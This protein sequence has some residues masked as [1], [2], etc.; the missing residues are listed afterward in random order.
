MKSKKILLLFLVVVLSVTMAAVSVAC[1]NKTIELA[2]LEGLDAEIDLD[3]NTVKVT[4]DSSLSILALPKPVLTEEGEIGYE[5][6]RDSLLKNIVE[7]D[8]VE[9]EYGDNTFYLKVYFAKSPKK[10]VKYHVIVTR[11]QPQTPDN[12]GGRQYGPFDDVFDGVFDFTDSGKPYPS[13]TDIS[14]EEFCALLKPYYVSAT[15]ARGVSE[16]DALKKFDA[17]KND[18]DFDEVPEILSASGVTLESL[19]DVFV[20]GEGVWAKILPLITKFSAE[21]A[22]IWDI[23]T[24]DVANETLIAEVFDFMGYAVDN[25]ADENTL[26]AFASTLCLLLIDTNNDP[27]YSS[28]SYRKMEK[29]EFYALLE[30]YGYLDEYNEALQ[31]GDIVL[32]SFYEVIYSAEIRKC[33]EG[34]IQGLLNLSEYSPDKIASALKTVSASVGLVMNNDVTLNELLSGNALPITEIVKSVNE[35][36]EILYAFLDGLGDMNEFSKSFVDFAE[37]YSRFAEDDVFSMFGGIPGVLSFIA[38]VFSELKAEDY[39]KLYFNFDD[40]YKE[41]DDEAKEKKFGYFIASAANY[42]SEAYSHLG[43][44]AKSTT[45]YLFK[46]FGLLPETV[47]VADLDEFMEYA[48]SKPEDDLTEEECKEITAAFNE[49]FLAGGSSLSNFGYH[50]VIVPLGASDEA[51]TEAL[52]RTDEYIYVLM[53]AIRN[54]VEKVTLSCDTSVKGYRDLIVYFDGV[55]SYKTQLF[56]FDPADIENGTTQL[57]SVNLNRIIYASCELGGSVSVSD[58]ADTISQMTHLFVK[59]EYYFVSASK[60]LNFDDVE[61]IGVDSSVAGVE[62]AAIVRV[63]TYGGFG[64]MEFVIV[65]YVYDENNPVITGANVSINHYIVPVGASVDDLGVTANYV[66]DYGFNHN[67]YG[68]ESN[69][70][71]EIDFSADA[72]GLT[73]AV[74]TYYINGEKRTVTLTVTVLSDEEY[75]KLKEGNWYV[76]MNDGIDEE[77]IPKLETY[78]Y[79]IDGNTTEAEFIEQSGI[80]FQNV[81]IPFVWSQGM[82]AYFSELTYSEF[83]NMLEKSGYSL[84][85]D[86]YNG[87]DSEGVP[88]RLTLSICD[89]YGNTVYQFDGSFSYVRIDDIYELAPEEEWDAPDAYITEI[90]LTEGLTGDAFVEEVIEELNNGYF[91]WTIKY[92]YNS[93]NV[94]GNMYGLEEAL[95]ASGHALGAEIVTPATAGGVGRVALT[96]VDSA[97]VRLGTVYE[98]D[99]RYAA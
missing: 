83:E 7:S 57:V 65:Y 4:V 56:V 95:S 96:I 29:E 32:E 37:A 45:L 27:Y 43:Y 70:P 98:L 71:C 86:F 49:T 68:A 6:Y 24:M 59:D 18:G 10:F 26:T 97:G 61:F 19:T 2:S 13:A 93:D 62:K 20:Y 17:A 50:P 67:Y 38:E 74:I 76:Y 58:I 31:T 90:T 12:G 21:N 79:I 11:P 80:N 52:E 28:N 44:G 94:V 73:D 63:G 54:N 47:D 53:E 35:A 39:I 85:T 5:Y 22:D 25:I 69:C 30:K 64:D 42:L 15:V 60:L 3:N 89:P 77:Y 9:L 66:Y 8:T 48:S 81:S 55:P 51:V 23:L 16:A 75:Y 87:I 33:A 1:N 41:K 14:L 92:R 82:S 84:V 46:L 78:A 91:Y 40:F 99:Y 88:R 36:G 34:V 72:P